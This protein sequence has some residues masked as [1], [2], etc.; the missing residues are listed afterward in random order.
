M[1]VIVIQNLSFSDVD[2]CSDGSLHMCTQH[3]INDT[4]GSHHC[5]CYVGYELQPDGFTCSGEL[6]CKHL[7]S[8]ST[9]GG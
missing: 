9:Q 3:C 5:D 6:D 7:D 2:E 1:T 4:V 8:E